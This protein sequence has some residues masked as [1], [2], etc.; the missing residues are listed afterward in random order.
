[1]FVPWTITTRPVASVIHRPAWPSG[2]FG[3][4]CA[5]D[6][7][8]AASA[9]AIQNASASERLDTLIAAYRGSLRV[10]VTT[11]WN[12]GWFW[13]GNEGS[14]IAEASVHVFWS[15]QAGS[16]SLEHALIPP[17]SCCGV[18]LVAASSD[19]RRAARQRLRSAL[20]GNRRRGRFP[21]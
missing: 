15:A 6:A 18:T 17:Y 19:A 14:E 12:V 11:C 10:S 1:M 5:T 13:N 2:S 4:A 7:E 16:G 3:D 9:Q 21:Q 8:P 20:A